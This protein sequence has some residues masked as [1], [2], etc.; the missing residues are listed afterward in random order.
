MTTR[1]KRRAAFF[2][3]DKTL[4][5]GNTGVLY[6]KWR[7]RRGESNALDMMRVAWWSAQYA[8]GIVDAGAVSRYAASTLRGIDE[9]AFAEQCREWFAEMVLPL[10]APVA[11]EVVEKHR[12]AGDVLVILTGSTPYAAGPLGE[13][14]GIPHVLASRLEVRAGAFTGRVDPPLCFGMGKVQRAEEFAAQ[15]DV[16]LSE[17]SFYTDSISDLPMLMR[18]GTPV[19]VN[20]DPRLARTARKRG[21]PVE[22]W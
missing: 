12:E 7:Y 14:L 5:R 19:V 3:M 22:R 4:V 8:A 20:P 11:P 16:D 21:W 13:R 6:A 18:V 2:D 10:V 17:S 9:A 1:I 15:H